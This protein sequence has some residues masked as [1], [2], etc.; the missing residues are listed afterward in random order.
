[1]TDQKLDKMMRRVLLDSLQQDEASVEQEVEPFVA[2]R[3]HQRQIKEMLKD[4]LKWL[5][6]K[7]KPIWKLV[8]QKV[9][10][11]LLVAS[12]GLGSL[13]AVSPTVRAT[14]I[15]WVTEWYETHI[16]YWFTGNDISEEMPQYIIVDIP[17]GYEEIA[18]E[19]IE[20]SNYVEKVYRSSSDYSTQDIYFDYTY[21]QQGSGADYDAVDREVVQVTVNGAEGYLFVADD[22]ENMWSTL[23]WI[24]EAENLQFSIDAAMEKKDIL[25]MAESIKLV[26]LPK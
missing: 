1:M 18:G 4:P 21:M 7:T 10:V 13:M 14:V 3:K 22:V 2:S 12:V 15:R 24:D 11:I 19:R 25:H 26:E 9:A 23:V 17:N 6:N 5:R 8:A 20:E 16:T